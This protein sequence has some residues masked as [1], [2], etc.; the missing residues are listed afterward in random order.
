MGGVYRRQR[1][2]HQHCSLSARR[3]EMSRTAK[4]CFPSLLTA[5]AALARVSSLSPFP[6]VVSRTLGRSLSQSVSRHYNDTMTSTQVAESPPG[7]VINTGC[8]AVAAQRKP[9]R[10]RSQCATIY[11]LSAA[12]LPIFLSFTRPVVIAVAA[13]AAAAAAAVIP[14]REDAPFL[15]TSWQKTATYLMQ[16]SHV[17]AV[18][19]P[20]GRPIVRSSG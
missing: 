13:A 19:A 3:A 14:R 2:E 7:S 12:R 8:C 11:E 18:P 6:S 20:E 1:R 9:R 16:C 4:S 15:A 17:I 10:W 5:V